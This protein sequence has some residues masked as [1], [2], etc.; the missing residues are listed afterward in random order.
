MIPPQT[1]TSPHLY[2]TAIPKSEIEDALQPEPEIE[3]APIWGK[4]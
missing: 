1:E 2:E 4:E 3:D